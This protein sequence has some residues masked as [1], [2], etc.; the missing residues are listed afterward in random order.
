MRQKIVPNASAEAIESLYYAFMAEPDEELKSICEEV[1]KTILKLQKPD[2]SWDY[3]TY[4]DGSVRK[5]LDF[6]QGYMIDGLIA[7]L[8]MVESETLKTQIEEAIIKG[9]EFYR[10]MFHPDGRAFY[11]NE[12]KMPTEIH[13]QTQGIIT[14]SK[15]YC[16]FG[17]K[18]DIDFAMKVA[19]WTI[20]NM[21]DKEGYFYYTKGKYFAN[22][23]PYMRWNEAWMLVALTTLIETLNLREK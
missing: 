10:G 13:N 3:A 6:H 8:Q 1:L 15:L 9:A 2:G 14:F 4:H 5:Q 12:K 23:I 17:K 16:T 22:K 11:R 18:E 20:Q 19:K 7:G 21:Q